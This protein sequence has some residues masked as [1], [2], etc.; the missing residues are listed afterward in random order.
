[1]N[2]FNNFTKNGIGIKGL[3][4]NTHISNTPK[5]NNFHITTVVVRNDGRVHDFFNTNGTYQGSKFGHISKKK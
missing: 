4:G 2:I 3:S 1:M 5:T